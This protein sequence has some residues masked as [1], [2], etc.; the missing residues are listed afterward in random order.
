MFE[1]AADKY[2]EIIHLSGSL[3]PREHFIIVFR[4]IV[5]CID[6]GCG[7]G[8]GSDGGRRC[9]LKCR[10]DKGELWREEDQERERRERERERDLEKGKKTKETQ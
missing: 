5:E 6:G 8:G 9:R 3:R 4:I 2:G 7:R 10:E 1:I